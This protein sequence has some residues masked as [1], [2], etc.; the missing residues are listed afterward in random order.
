MFQ[1]V[2]EGGELGRSLGRGYMDD[3]STGLFYHREFAQVFSVRGHTSYSFDASSG[4]MT[5][6]I[7]YSTTFGLAIALTRPYE[8]SSVVFCKTKEWR[9]K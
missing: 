6:S 4:A 2:W 3:F 1:L 9:V 5:D 7:V 8:A